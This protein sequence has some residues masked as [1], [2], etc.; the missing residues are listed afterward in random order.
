MYRQVILNTSTLGD[1]NNGS[2]AINPAFP[3]YAYRVES[4]SFVQNW[5][6][7]NSSNNTLLFAETGDATP[8][9]ANIAVGTYDATSILSALGNALTAA[10]SQS[11]TVTYDQITRRLSI[12]APT[13]T[14]KILPGNRG[15]TAF[16]S[17]GVNKSEETGYF[18]SITLPNPLNVSASQPIL[19]TSR[20]F[21]ANNGVIYPAG[22]NSEMNILACISPDTFGD[23]VVW[24]NPSDKF[25]HLQNGTTLNTIDFQLVDSTTLH[26]LK[27][28][29]PSVVVLG[30]L[31]DQ[32]DADSL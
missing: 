26:Q 4:V 17:L 24:T 27:T 22:I 15:S 8:R 13:K 11:Y 3:I 21:D 19:L 16:L 1:M 28:S 10:G 7:T 31:D 32:Y 29:S 18:S 9:K 20:T 6:A 30:V 12:S 23:V 25:H 2:F 14:F 5:D